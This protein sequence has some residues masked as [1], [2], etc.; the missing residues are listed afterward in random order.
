MKAVSKLEGAQTS[1]TSGCG[2]PGVASALRDADHSRRN[3]N[4]SGRMC[5]QPFSVGNCFKIKN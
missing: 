5:A 2:L 4:G 3:V 1:M